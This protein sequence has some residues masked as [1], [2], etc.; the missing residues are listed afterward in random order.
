MSHFKFQAYPSY[1]F[2][3]KDGNID[4]NYVKRISHINLEDLKKKL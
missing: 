1:A 2:I 4:L 3:D